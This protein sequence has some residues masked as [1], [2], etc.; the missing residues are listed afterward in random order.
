MHIEKISSREYK[1]LSPVAFKDIVV[2]RGF[3]FDGASV[4]RAF[5]W[6]ASPFT[7]NYT[8]GALIH[9]WLYCTE[10]VSKKEADNIFY[11]IMLI[12]GVSRWKATAMYMAVKVFG[13]SV[14]GKH[15]IQEVN[16]CRKLGQLDFVEQVRGC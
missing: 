6:F 15:T 11:K 8:R 3:V 16:K 10:L 14:Y 1:L 12:D 4:P 13:C 9:D 2:P 7:G 5:W